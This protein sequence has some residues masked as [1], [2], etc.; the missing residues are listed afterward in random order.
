MDILNRILRYVPKGGSLARFEFGGGLRHLD[1]LCAQMGVDVARTK[2]VATFAVI[3]G[4]RAG[5]VLDKVD[6]TRFRSA[7]MR[8]TYCG[9]GRLDVV[10]V[11]KEF[12]RC[13]FAPTGN[14]LA[15]LTHCTRY[16]RGVRRFVQEFPLQKVHS[17]VDAF[18]DSDW[19]RC[20]TE[21]KFSGCF[22][23]MCGGH[24]VLFASSTHKV[25][26][27]SCVEAD[28]YSGVRIISQCYGFIS[29]LANLGW[30]GMRARLHL[31]FSFAKSMVARRGA[32]TIRHVATHTLSVQSKVRGGSLLL[33]KVFGKENCADLGTKILSSSKL[34]HQ[35]LHRMRFDVRCGRSKLAKAIVV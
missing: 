21:R 16:L 25:I 28:S 5:I 9:I 1:V 24:C 27:L 11:A 18:S 7:V 32:G 34:V 35:C 20:S 10:L 12:S 26:S 2:I 6:H 30:V 14:A 15:T 33:R 22:A 31:D 8:L 4:A 13:M 17:I 3:T 29:F 19:A 23:L